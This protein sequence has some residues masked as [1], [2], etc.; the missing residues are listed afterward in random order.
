MFPYL[1]VYFSGNSYQ[2]N[3]EF[4]TRRGGLSSSSFSFFL[5]KEIFSLFPPPISWK[6]EGGRRREAS[7]V[8]ERGGCFHCCQGG[9]RFFHLCFPP[10]LRHLFLMGRH[11]RTKMGSRG[12]CSSL[13]LAPNPTS[14][15]S[16]PPLVTPPSAAVRERGGG[17]TFARRGCD[18]L[19]WKTRL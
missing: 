12:S 8:K 17:R 14:G 13:T 11:E 7:L 15:F 2:C 16:S 1:L 6:R 4:R 9:R 10:L 19:E 3:G 18:P 5:R